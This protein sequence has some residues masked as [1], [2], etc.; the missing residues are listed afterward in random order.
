MK[1]LLIV[2]ITALLLA[3][4]GAS[5]WDGGAARAGGFSDGGDRATPVTRCIRPSN[6]PTPSSQCP[7][8]RPGPLSNYGG[9]EGGGPIFCNTS[10]NGWYTVQENGTFQCQY[11]YH[12]SGVYPNGIYQGG[13]GYEG[14]CPGSNPYYG[15]CWSWQFLHFP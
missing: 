11:G 9:F 2:L 8:P 1:K 4:A 5:W 14:F 3:V 10:H 13:W 12:Y 7:T 15:S 6:K